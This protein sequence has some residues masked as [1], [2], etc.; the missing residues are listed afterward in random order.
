MMPPHSFLGTVSRVPMEVERPKPGKP[1]ASAQRAAQLFEDG[2]NGLKGRRA[3]APSNS[4][5]SVAK[6][7]L[8]AEKDKIG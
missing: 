3:V 5:I 6:S 4:N 1:W 8:Q 7:K 2:P